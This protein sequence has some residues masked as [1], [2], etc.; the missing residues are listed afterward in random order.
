M[1]NPRISII[2]VCFNA[3]KYI[4]RT[5]LSVIGQT[6]KNVEYIVVDGASK[7]GTVQTIK[8]YEQHISHWIS[9]KDKSLYDAMN[10]GLHMAT[11]DYIWYMN[12]GDCIYDDSTLETIAG[13]MNGEDFVYG[14]A[15][16]V[17]ESGDQRPWHK[18]KPGQSEISY[19]S[20]INGM[21][22]CHHAMMVKRE[23]VAEYALGPWKLSSDIDWVIR[24]LKNC[25]TYL[26]TET[27]WCRYL[28]GGLSEVKRP[29]SLM[30]RFSI[31]RKHFGLIPTLL[32]QVKIIFQFIR[33]GRVFF[34][35]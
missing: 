30:E 8:K 5:I 25:K 12:A 3:E 35:L 21:V 11:G 23:L 26:D 29:K 6:Y 10:K 18:K 33:R 32:Q 20:F 19:R 4:E 17:N 15:V 2:T 13:K 16:I 27:I 24:T 7:D 9:E 28:E 1:K 31:S 34:V 14:D 22:I